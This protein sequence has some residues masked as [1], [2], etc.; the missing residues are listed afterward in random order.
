MSSSEKDNMQV[1]HS[2]NYE[3]ID[4]LDYW[5]SDDFFLKKTLGRKI[6]MD[7]IIKCNFSD[8]KGSMLDLF[9]T[10]ART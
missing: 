9:Y 6:W 5:I 10:Y 1:I 8:I 4:L 3:S 2:L 7:H